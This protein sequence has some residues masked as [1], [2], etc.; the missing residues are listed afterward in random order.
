[1]NPPVRTIARDRPE[2]SRT[3][4]DRR[5]AAV[6]LF[7]L[8]LAAPAVAQQPALRIYGIEDGL[9]FPQVF[10]VFQDSR[11]FLWAGTSYGL[12]RYDGTSFASLTK[13]QGLP[14]D[15]VRAI[16]EDGAGTVWVLTEQGV[17]RIAAI[18]GPM[19]APTV[20]PLPAALAALRR[21]PP[22]LM[23]VHAG[24]VW[25]VAG[26]RLIR[27]RDGRLVEVPLPREMAGERIVALGPA[28]ATAVWVCTAAHAALLGGAGEAAA[29]AA[30]TRFGPVAAVVA[31]GADVLLL[32]RDGI[33]RLVAGRFRPAPEW[34]LPAGTSAT[35]AVALGGGLVL[36]TPGHGVLLVRPGV[37]PRRLATAEGLPSDTIYGA[38]VDREGLL[39]LATADGLVKVFDLELRSYPTRRPEIGAMVFCFAPAAGGGEWVGHSEGATRVRGASLAFADARRGP[40]D[41]PGVWALLTLPGGAA[42]AGTR[43]GVALLRRRGVRFLTG[44]PAAAQGRIFGLARDAVENIWA[45]TAAGAVRFRWDDR[46]ERPFGAEAFTAVDG[47]PFGEA[48]GIATAPDGTVWFGTDGAGVVRW[49]GSAMRRFGRESGLPSTVCRAVLVRPGGVWVGTDLGLWS[50]AGGRATPVEAVNRALNERYIVALA[51]SGDA[52]WLATPYEVVKVVNGEVAARLDQAEGLIGASTTAENCLAVRDDGALLVGMVGGF[53]VVPRGWGARPRLDPSVLMLGVEGGNGRPVTAGARL[54]YRENTVTFAFASPSYLAEQATRFQERLVGYDDRWSPPHANPQQ[55]YTNLPAGEYVFEVRAVAGDGRVSARPAHFAFAVAPPWFETVPARA[56]LVLAIGAV[57]YGLALVR[58]RRVRRR[59]EE[60]EALVDKRTRALAAANLALERLATTD[61]LTGIANRR[62]FEERLASEAA[63]AE[64]EGRT[65]SLLMIDVD[66]FKAYNDAL[67]HQAGDGCLRRIAELAAAH[68]GRAGDLAARWGGEEFAV[69][70]VGTGAE[71]T[72]AVAEKVRAAVAQLAIPHPASPVAA[73]V[74][75]SIGAA[76]VRALPGMAP[77]TLVAAADAALYEA[78][79]AGRNR[80][81]AAATV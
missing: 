7:A 59:N 3:W 63:R 12:S 53:T 71:G 39:W 27:F 1:M 35:G 66:H 31:I 62:V 79:R 77:A 15:S 50:L 43:H 20:L 19:G 13:A 57:A 21:T 64:R 68:A 55:R 26:G 2:R 24:S 38:A 28:G 48:R 23:A 9:K 75:I 17:A 25:L 42:L 32:Q 46:H 52:V 34:G 14:H 8:L 5:V 70:L 16:G 54:T 60:L 37:P 81:V 74:T 4:R 10:A 61:A 65:L 45:S 36:V 72:L 78:K 22:T 6:A 51:A 18:G 44:L 40:A 73:V 11:G 67:G 30:P 29:L 69:L 47:A 80:V 76:T 49:D 58:T 33:S 41:E 56:G